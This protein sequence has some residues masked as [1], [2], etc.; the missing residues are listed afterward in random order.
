MALGAAGLHSL[1]RGGEG[2]RVGSE[3]SR[4]REAWLP[5]KE[6]QRPLWPASGSTSFLLTGKGQ[7]DLRLFLTNRLNIE[8]SEYF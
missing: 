8:Y 3:S 2:P 7:E 5:A 1:G 6:K 4:R